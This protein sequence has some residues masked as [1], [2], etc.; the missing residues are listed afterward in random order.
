MTSIIAAILLGLAGSLHCVGMCGPI[1]LALPVHNANYFNRI[2][3]ALSY[4]FGRAI[5]YAL[6]GTLVGLFGQGLNWM[7]LQQIVSI[8]LGISILLYYIIP[9]FFSGSKIN[10]LYSKQVYRLKNTFN[11]FLK[12]RNVSALFIIG[13]LNGLLPCGLVYTALVASLVLSGVQQA[14]SFMFFFGM[15][16]LPLMLSIIILKDWIT[17]KFQSRINKFLPTLMI[18]MAV[19]FIFRGLN[20]GIPYVSPKIN[21]D[22]NASCH[23]VTIDSKKAH[24]CVLS[25]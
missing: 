17:I 9:D 15:G 12:K 10:Q 22:S 5:T 3:G 18:I 4:N 25:K 6:L 23:N 24:A 11:P 20:L 13:I 7:G 8:V 19:L 14:A 21:K 2:L 1:A 16:T